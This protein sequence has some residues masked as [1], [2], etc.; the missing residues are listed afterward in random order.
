MS[1]DQEIVYLIVSIDT[2]E[3]DWGVYKPTGHHLTNI[4]QLP[5]LQELFDRYKIK[6]TYLIDYPVAADET[7]KD[8]FKTIH[9]TGRAEIGAHLHPWNTPPF[10]EETTTYNSMLKNLPRDLQKKKITALTE[11]IERKL[12]IR[13]TSFRAGRFCFDEQT[14]PTLVELNYFVDSSVTP[15]INWETDYGGI[16]FQGY[17]YYPYSIGSQNS[18]KEINTHQ[19]DGT[20]WEVPVTIGFNRTPFKL[21]SSIYDFLGKD[22]LRVLRLRGIADKLGLLKKIWLSPELSG[23]KEMQHLS[24][25]IIGLGV[26]VLNLFF[27][28]TSL[29]PGFSPFIKTDSDRD[30]FFRTLE[31]FF[32]WLQDNYNL[33]S[34]SLS[35]YCQIAITLDH[36]KALDALNQANE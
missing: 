10:Q 8:F 3:D 25:V 15:F 27:H 19:R 20:L 9:D 12:G 7:H 30:A 21:C 11:L 1:T 14:P 26:P 4:G 29:V 32:A 6:P 24:K 16:N 36:Q 23:Y 34:V 35:E 18:Q 28:S 22:R 13:P 31:L 33:K 17:P 2:E 5:K